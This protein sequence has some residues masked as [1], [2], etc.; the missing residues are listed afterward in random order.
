MVNRNVWSGALRLLG[1]A[2]FRHAYAA[3]THG[4]GVIDVIVVV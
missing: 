4:V 2:V 1:G 3:Q